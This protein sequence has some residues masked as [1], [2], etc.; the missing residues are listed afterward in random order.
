MYLPQK[1]VLFL[2]GLLGYTRIRRHAKVQSWVRAGGVVFEAVSQPYVLMYLFFVYAATSSDWVYDTDAG[3]ILRWFRV[4][5]GHLDRPPSLCVAVRE[6]VCQ[7]ASCIGNKCNTNEMEACMKRF[8][9]PCD[10]VEIP[11]ILRIM[12]L[13]SPFAWA[14]C[15]LISIYHTYLHAQRGRPWQENEMDIWRERTTMII[16]LPPVYGLFSLTGVVCKVVLL[17]GLTRNSTWHDNTECDHELQKVGRN[18]ISQDCWLR[19]LEQLRSGFALSLNTA[20]MFAA[21][22]L[23]CFATLCMTYVDVQRKRGVLASSCS[24]CGQGRKENSFRTGQE[25]ALTDQLMSPLKE[26]TMQGVN[27]FVVIVLIQSAVYMVV[28]VLSSPHPLDLHYETAQWIKSALLSNNA[29]IAGFVFSSSTIALWDLITFERHMHDMLVGFQPRL[30]FLSAKLIVSFAFFQEIAVKLVSDL[31][32]ADKAFL[33][34]QQDLFYAS[35][36]CLEMPVMAVLAYAAWRPRGIAAPTKKD[37]D[38][39]SVVFTL[40]NGEHAQQAEVIIKE[41][42]SRISGQD[43]PLTW[44]S[45]ASVR[46][47]SPQAESGQ[48]V[49]KELGEGGHAG[50]V[51]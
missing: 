24:H 30:K 12:V 5:E 47:L 7:Q 16:A 42:R 40:T 8:P 2:I 15:V 28:D 25:S 48:E 18:G 26:L 9:E 41:V 46:L 19:R 29:F 49:L 4:G 3:D 6:H 34:Q 50:G 11:D 27:F 22:S 45:S 43:E 1:F 32:P 36:M 14:I 44:W 39:R 10:L 35:L 17:A 37:V 51:A 33:E 23:W 20:D 13:L 21:V 31:I 38:A